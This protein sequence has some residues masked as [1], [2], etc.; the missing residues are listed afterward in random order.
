MYNINFPKLFIQQC[1]KQNVLALVYSL[2]H[3]WHALEFPQILNLNCA[4]G[5]HCHLLQFH[6]QWSVEA[7]NVN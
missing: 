7:T 3:I 4:E 6:H 5:K 2:Q 1:A